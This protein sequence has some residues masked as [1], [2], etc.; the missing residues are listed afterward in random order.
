MAAGGVERRGTKKEP[1]SRL[2]IYSNNHGLLLDSGSAV[3]HFESDHANFYSPVYFK[4]TAYTSSGATVTSDERLKNT[5]RPLSEDERYAKF[6]KMLTPVSFKYNDGTSGRTHMGMIAQAVKEAL[7]AAGFTTQEIAAFVQYQQD[8]F[9]VNRTD[10]GTVCALRY[11]EFTALNTA[12]IQKQQTELDALRK[13]IAE[14]KSM[15]SA[16]KE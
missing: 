13:E 15:L 14:L 11:E 4:S 10:D 2:N 12:M 5:I 9:D 7:Q 6:F 8:A 16:S 3:T 1:G